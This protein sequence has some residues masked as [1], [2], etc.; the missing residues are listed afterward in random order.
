MKIKDRKKIISYAIAFFIAL[1]LFNSID[2]SAKQTNLVTPRSV[3]LIITGGNTSI[4]GDVHTLEDEN[5]SYNVSG[6][7]TITER[8]E[9]NKNMILTLDSANINVGDSQTAITYAPAISIKNN[10]NVTLILVGSSEVKGGIGSAGIFVEEG[11]SL[12]IK[13]DGSLKATGGNTHDTFL[14][15]TPSAG[16]D[17]IFAAGAGIGGNGTTSHDQGQTAIAGSTNNF[18]SIVIDSGTVN[19]FGGSL[20]DAN[21]GAGAGIGSGGDATR[22]G[23]TNGSIT[24]NNGMVNATGGNHLDGSGA[25]AGIGA[26][27]STQAGEYNEIKILINNGTI[28]A[29]GNVGGAAI[30]GGSGTIGGEITIT[31]GDVN[32]NSKGSATENAGGAAIGGGANAS[33]GTIVISGGK[34]IAKVENTAAAGIGGG[35]NGGSRNITIKGNADVLAAGGTGLYRNDRGGAGIGTGHVLYGDRYGYISSG[36]ISLL[37]TAKIK[38]YAGINAQ[39]IGMGSGTGADTIDKNLLTIQDKISLWAQTQTAGI[40][41]LVDKSIRANSELVYL[42]SNIYLTFSSDVANTAK[43]YLK[44][45][46][47]GLE[48]EKDFPYTWSSAPE[49]LSIEQTIIPISSQESWMNTLASWATLYPVKNKEINYT[50]TYKYVGSV[51]KAAKLPS[52]DIVAENTKYSAK[53]QN[54]VSG[55]TFKGWYLDKACTKKFVNGTKINSNITLYGKWTQDNNSSKKKKMPNSGYDTTILLYLCAIVVASSGAL[56]QLRKNS[57]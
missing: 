44:S 51:P 9:I 47:T 26:G 13:G 27:A 3:S 23:N 21:I 1:L 2:M 43:G 38:A 8:I 20:K 11:S 54:S 4:S 42:S 39:A 31:G 10:A 5:A 37:N 33:S 7:S 57:N 29:H 49:T 53:K 55:Y 48:L 25:G 36:N 16:L 41:V 32:A 18:G 6:T 40:P 28:N 30:G 45:S 17:L 12:T 46:N 14:S 19:A 50:V 56:V 34:I 15:N 22:S 52:K 35:T 24:I